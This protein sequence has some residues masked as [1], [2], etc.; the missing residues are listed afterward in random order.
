MGCRLS[1]WHLGG[2]ELLCSGVEQCR[3]LLLCPS[4]SHF[5]RPIRTP[6]IW[7]SPSHVALALGASCHAQSGGSF[8]CHVGPLGFVSVRLP[9]GF[10]SRRSCSFPPTCHGSFHV[11]CPSGSGVRLPYRLP[12]HRHREFFLSRLPAS[13]I[14][15]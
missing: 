15:L 7:T 1:V 6:C 8:F 9:A 2:S 13:F 10:Y 12:C 14:G 3:L 11:P 5:K 4:F